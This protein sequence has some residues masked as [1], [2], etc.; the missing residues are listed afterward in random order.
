MMARWHAELTVPT[1]AIATDTVLVLEAPD[2][3]AGYMWLV[4]HAATLE[5]EHLFVAPEHHR[6]GYGRHLFS[7]AVRRARAAGHPLVVES[8]PYAADFYTAMGM[9]HEG[10]RVSATIPG[11]SLPLLRLGVEEN[12]S[13]RR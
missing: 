1:E 9:T 7:E 5:I 2:L 8:D 3:I 4:E 6:R 12:Q 13:A 10:T 11:R